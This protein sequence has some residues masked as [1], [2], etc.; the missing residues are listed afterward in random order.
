ME[1]TATPANR[2]WLIMA[3]P[4]YSLPVY[5]WQLEA[6]A[7]FDHIVHGANNG[8]AAQASVRYY[9]D[10]DDQVRAASSFPLPDSRKVQVHLASGGEDRDIH[11]LAAHAPTGGSN[12]WAAV[13][14]RAIVPPGLDEVAN[15]ILTFDAPMDGGV[16]FTGPITLSLRFSCSEIDSHVIARLGRVDNDGGYHLLS[17]GSIRPA[18]RKIDPLRTTAS[19]IAIDIDTP[20]PLV[21]GTPVTLL[22]SL[23]PHPVVFKPGEK[24]RLDIGSR[25]DLLRSDVAHGYEQFDMMVPPYFSRNT[26]HFGEISYLEL[27][28]RMT[29]VNSPTA[30]LI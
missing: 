25:T 10:G 27:D 30:G 9:A 8:Y 1:K 23:T 2:K 6:L 15:P 16:E 18:C 29:V 26:I 24:L 7:F 14:F 11:Q 3:P 21:P 12:R 13:P 22:F 17:M 4:E 5:R 28:Q 20:E 19:E